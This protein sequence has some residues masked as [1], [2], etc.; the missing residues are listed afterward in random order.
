[1]GLT[2][3]RDRANPAA[4]PQCIIAMPFELKP[5]ISSDI[6]RQIEY[7]FSHLTRL[8]LVYPPGASS[9]GSICSRCNCS[10][11]LSA[12]AMISFKAAS[13]LSS[14]AKRNTVRR[15]MIQ[16]RNHD[17]SSCKPDMASPRYRLILTRAQH[18]CQQKWRL[19]HLHDTPPYP[20]TPSPTFVHSSRPA[21][22]THNGPCQI[23]AVGTNSAVLPVGCW[24][25][26]SQRAQ[27]AAWAAANSRS[28]SAMRLRIESSSC[29]SSAMRSSRVS[30]IFWTRA[31]DSAPEARGLG[32]LTGLAESTMGPCPSLPHQTS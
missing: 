15:R 10:N 18:M 25:R 4:M 17:S 24:Y 31:F 11:R 16:P 28:S 13:T 8:L 20:L 19:E 14:F 26:E 32:F 5:G 21:A 7:W 23:G 22:P 29:C 9:N 12:S 6:V 3:Q 30:S 1:M 2:A 27:F